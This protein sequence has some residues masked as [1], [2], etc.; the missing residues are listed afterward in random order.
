MGLTQAPFPRDGLSV[1]INDFYMSINAIIEL[2]NNV[3]WNLVFDM[4]P[5]IHGFTLQNKT[6]EFITRHEES[7][8]KIPALIAKRVDM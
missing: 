8:K 6:F 4:P 2:A 7:C 5:D 3:N 1:S